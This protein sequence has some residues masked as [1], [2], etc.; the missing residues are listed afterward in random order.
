VRYKQ[1]APG[2]LASEPAFFTGAL[3]RHHVE[4]HDLVMPRRKQRRWP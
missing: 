4:I 3:A 1:F 2:I